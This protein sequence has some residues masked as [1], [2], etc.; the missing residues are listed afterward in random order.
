MKQ[1]S[2]HTKALIDRLY[3]SIYL[4]EKLIGS[5]DDAEILSEIG[6]SGEP[7]AIIDIIP[8]IL[9]TNPAVA[10]VAA[11]A[12]HKLILGTTTD[13]LVW[14]DHVLRKKFS[15]WGHYLYEWHKLSPDDLGKLERFEDASVSLLEM[16][17][18]HQSGYV[19]EEAIKR[20]ALI[21]SGA[22]L[23]FL[24]LRANDWVANVRDA[25]YDA[26]RSRLKPDYARHF[27]RTLTL[28]SRLEK[29][30]RYDHKPLVQAIYQLLQS[31]ECRTAL[32]ESLEA[33]DRFIRRACFKL[34]L[35]STPCE[36]WSNRTRRPYQSNYTPHCSTLM[37]PCARRLDITYANSARRM[38]PNS[39]DSTFWLEK[40]QL[41]I[42]SSA[43]WVKL[44]GRTMTTS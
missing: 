32:L 35:N 13:E 6:N 40:V 23:Q 25:T 39:I 16:A 43:D 18:F 42:Q 19:R 36:S 17:S 9:A 4:W 44:V 29:A 22:E 5:R 10:T 41:F 33:E 31:E 8:F 27:I 7:A 1:R 38:S 2:P 26:I 37:P 3:E 12:V 30:G 21:T 15:Y 14:L 28:V 20:L 34:A 24:L 11:K